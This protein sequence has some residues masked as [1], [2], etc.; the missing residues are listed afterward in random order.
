MNVIHWRERRIKSR[1][2]TPNL[3]LNIRL[4]GLKGLFLPPMSVRCLDFNRYG[5][6]FFS[7]RELKPKTRILATFKGK[8]IALSN[9]PGLVTE[10]IAV[11]GGYRMS[12]RFAYAMENQLYDRNTDNALSRIEHLYHPENC[13]QAS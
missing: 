12:V 6:A 3:R 7:T 10:S 8:Y 11:D 5:M 13:R 4:T 2:K 9:V 1:H